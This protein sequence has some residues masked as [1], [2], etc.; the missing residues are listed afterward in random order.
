MLLL[1]V[2]YWAQSGQKVDNLCSLRNL[3][4]KVENFKTFICV[5]FFTKLQLY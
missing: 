3:K 1:L 5:T 2:W 4:I